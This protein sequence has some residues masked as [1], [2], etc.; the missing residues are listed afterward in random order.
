[1]NA[2][3]A[4]QLGTGFNSS[5]GGRLIPSLNLG[6]GGDSFQIL[7]SSTGVATKAY[8]HSAYTLGVYRAWESGDLLLGRVV[9]GFG[10]GAL[11]AL[12]TYQDTG[13]PEEKKNDFAAGPAFFGRWVLVG[14][15]YSSV[16]AIL[17]IGDPRYKLGDMLT[18]NFRD[19][20]NFSV[21]LEF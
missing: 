3:A 15:L 7:F 18:L 1:M 13:A 4:I 12:R 14:I 10:I 11:Y 6:F 19:H 9:S 20:V 17:G 5:T 2:E 21:G 8:S 16:E